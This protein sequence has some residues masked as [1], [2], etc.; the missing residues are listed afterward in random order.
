MK[1]ILLV[2]P[3]PPY[4]GGVSVSV[5]R[6]YDIL[7]KAGYEVTKYDTQLANT[8]LNKFK[9]LKFIKFLFLPLFLLIHKKFDVIHFHVS[10]IIPK[11]YVA[12]WRG[13]FSRK[14]KF[15]V[16]LHGQAGNILK[17]ASGVYSLDKFDRIIC[18]KEGDCLLMPENLKFKA[19]EI[20]A[21]IP[22]A[23]TR[24]Y[25]RLPCNLNVPDQSSFRMLISGFIVINE[26][27]NDLYGFLD[28]INLLD[29]LRKSGRNAELILVVL[30]YNFD[31]KMAEYLKRLK[32]D[33]IIRGLDKQVCW[34]EG[35]AMELWPLLKKVHVLLRPT[36]SDGDALSIR[37]S[38][39]LKIPVI[40]SNVV[41]RPSGSIVYDINSPNDLYNKTVN[42]IDNYEDHIA[43]IGNNNMSFAE[44]IIEQYENQ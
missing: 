3:F 13:L 27:Y 40:T 38:L 15:I 11:L 28:A 33:C 32:S 1:R 21:F 16:T 44:E 6:L 36:K 7:I 4:I 35:V 23:M 34:I 12:L 31:R 8:H 25:S 18:V 10:G 26:K 37:E 2:S 29:K 39:F 22:P 42:L 30:G 41:P 14:T 9:V 17:S 19:V 20:P 24:T 5:K 43:M